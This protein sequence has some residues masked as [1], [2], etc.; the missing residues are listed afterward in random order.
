MVHQDSYAR[1][2]DLFV[3]ALPLEE[4]GFSYAK[5][6]LTGRPPY[7]PSVLLKLY[8]YGYR[9]GIRS[10][11]KLHQACPA[12]EKMIT[13]GRWYNKNG[14]KVKHYKTKGC[15]GCRLRDQCTKNKNGRFIERNYYQPDIEQNQAR[16]ESNPD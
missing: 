15:N 11:N 6:E 8:M 9:H 4:L 16:V 5:H 3:Y 12:G 13:N 7:H 2:V 1:L 14:H 10:T